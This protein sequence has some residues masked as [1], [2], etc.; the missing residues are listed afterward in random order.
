MD[1]YSE[2]AM[3]I[4]TMIGDDIFA[5]YLSGEMID[6]TEFFPPSPPPS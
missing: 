2:S 1:N 4:L 3:N 5:K 6:F